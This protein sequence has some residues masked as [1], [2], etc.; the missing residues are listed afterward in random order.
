MSDPHTHSGFQPSSPVTI[1]DSI[2]GE[3]ANTS[4]VDIDV[5]T[6]S[7]PRTIVVTS[8]S[9]PL[10]FNGN[11]HEPYAS[12]N[13]DKPDEL[14]DSEEGEKGEQ[15]GELE[16][17]AELEELEL[18]AWIEPPTIESRMDVKYLPTYDQQEWTRRIMEQQA[19][20]GAVSDVL[21]RKM[22]R[23]FPQRQEK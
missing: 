9:V 18:S 23:I 3:T 4:D 21:V 8:G 22:L 5:D 16:E 17:P 1:P 12:E 14:E 15:L 19:E 11:P 13:P 6:S 20:E 2:E 7:S 10:E